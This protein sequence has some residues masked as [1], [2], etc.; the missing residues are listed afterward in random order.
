MNYAEFIKR[1]REIRDL[2]YVESHRQGDT[3]IGKTLEDLLGIEENNIAGPDFS[4]YEL[5]SGRK[6][7]ISM[8]TL[9]TKTPAP[10]DAIKRLLEEFGY[11]QRKRPKDRVQT[12]LIG[13]DDRASFIPPED[14]ELHVTVDSL[15]P[16]SVGLQLSIKGDRLYIDNEKGVEAYYDDNVLKETFE[17]KYHNLVYVLADNRISGSNEYFWFNEAYLLKNFSFKRFSKLV[18]DGILK[19]DL[20]IGHYPDGRPHDHGTAFRILPKYLPECF[21]QIDRII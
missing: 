6:D 11:P 14:K 15:K 10:R 1:I 9:F 18:R 5:K 16:N 7:S 4:T 3:G 13:K 12:T 17:S 8:L 20:R 21:E 19:L 2:D